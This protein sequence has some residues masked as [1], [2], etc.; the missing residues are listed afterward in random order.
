MMRGPRKID[1]QQIAQ[2][3][4]AR[5]SWYFRVYKDY[6]S[7]I[8]GNRC[9]MYPSCS[10]YGRQVFCRYGP[11]IGFFMTTDRLTRCGNDLYK[12]RSFFDHGREY[13]IDLP[14]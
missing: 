1:V 3:D 6:I 2:D 13:F 14:R 11:L 5:D 7:P 9:P 4:S 8:A 12:Y 10:Q